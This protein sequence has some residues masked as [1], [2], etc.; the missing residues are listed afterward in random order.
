M[1]QLW[2]RIILGST[3]IYV[4]VPV[5]FIFF[6]KTSITSVYF[7]NLL[8]SILTITTIISLVNWFHIS[9]CNPYRFYD[10]V[11]VKIC[12]GLMVINCFSETN[13]KNAYYLL[14]FLLM[15]CLCYCLSSFFTVYMIPSIRKIKLLNNISIKYN[16]YFTPNRYLSVLF[17][18]LFR[19]FSFLFTS[20]STQYNCDYILSFSIKYFISIAFLIPLNK[21]VNI[22]NY[23]IMY[24][25][26]TIYFI[27]TIIMY[28]ITSGIL[29]SNL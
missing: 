8:A 7:S 28:V 25:L 3:S 2:N 5:T 11:F 19:Y 13:Y 24:F 27:L 6:D 21:F 23:H 26:T 20:L 1:T 15:S 4:M 10:R 22:N 14:S 17:H 16:R 12:L 18:I 29:D 9:H